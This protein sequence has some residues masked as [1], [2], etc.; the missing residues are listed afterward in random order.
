MC[1][2]ESAVPL[3]V[4]DFVNDTHIA[5][6]GNQHIGSRRCGKLRRDKLGR[7]AAGSHRAH[8]VMPHA[9]QLLIQILYKGHK[10]RIRVYVRVIR[11][12]AVDVGQQDQ[13]I[14]VHQGSHNGR[15]GVVITVENLKSRDTVIG[16]DIGIAF[17]PECAQ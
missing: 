11:I 17:S 3:P 9:H 5:A 6:I 8:R 7:H 12:E 1:L 4:H 2:K 14:R 15:Q 16:A 10:L 13:K